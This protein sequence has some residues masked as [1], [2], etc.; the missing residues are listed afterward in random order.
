M[1]AVMSIEEI[2]SIYSKGMTLAAQNVE[3]GDLGACRRR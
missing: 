3:P 1:R 2:Y